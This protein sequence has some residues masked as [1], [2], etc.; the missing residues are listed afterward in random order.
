MV[1]GA[2]DSIL[3]VTQAQTPM[4]ERLGTAPDQKRHVIVPSGHAVTVPEVRLVVIKEVLDWLDKYLGG[5]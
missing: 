3:P 5:T 1:N 4:F 2:Y